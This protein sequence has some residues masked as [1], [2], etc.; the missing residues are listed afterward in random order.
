MPKLIIMALVAGLASSAFSGM[1]Q[2]TAPKVKTEPIHPTSAASGEEMY[3]T[4]CAA[5]H[6]A[7]GKGNGPAAQALKTHPPDLSTLSQRNGGVFPAAKVNSVLRFGANAP[8]HGTA[9]MPVWGDLMLTLNKG[10]LD[11]ERNIQQRIVNLTN[12]LKQMQ[13]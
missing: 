12:Y 5:C 11:S 7:E 4:Y 13:N 6:G 1:A 8:A 3:V 2:N 10:N 9:E